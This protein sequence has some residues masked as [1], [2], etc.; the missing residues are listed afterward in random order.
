MVS[1]LLLN[2]D[3]SCIAFLGVLWLTKCRDIKQDKGRKEGKKMYQAAH[4]SGSQFL[5]LRVRCKNSFRGF[6]GFKKN[7]LPASGVPRF[8]ELL[9]SRQ[10]HPET[11]QVSY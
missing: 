11:A 8:L 6:A 3:F 5:A 10:K 4:A 9:G 7:I 1:F 2:I